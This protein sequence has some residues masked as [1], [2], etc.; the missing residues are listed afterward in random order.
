MITGRRM[1][2]DDLMATPEDGHRFELVRGEIVR[3]PP[4]KGDHGDIEAALVG[5]IGYYLHERALGKGWRESG[6]RGARNGLVG[7]LISG[8]TGI[9]FSTPTDSDQTRGIDVGYLS[10]EQV[11]RLG[12]SSGAEY[13]SEVPALVAEVISPSESSEYVEKKVSDLLAGG[14]LLVWLLYPKPRTARIC[15]P[16]GST[17]LVGP[18]GMLQGGDVLPGFSVALVSL[19]P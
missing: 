10:T 12:V 17:R 11:A 2:F 3:T 7:R 9:R 8:G 18:E 19:F 6:G 16:D 4:P 5:A 1:T 14:A 13:I 15:L